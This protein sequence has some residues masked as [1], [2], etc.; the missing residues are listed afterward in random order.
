M[1][2]TR[3]K[4]EERKHIITSMIR[5]ISLC[6]FSKETI[7]TLCATADMLRQYEEEGKTVSDDELFAGFNEMGTM[8]K[9]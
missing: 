7:D 3:E 4:Y 2:T 6:D 5:V 9:E 8:H 1:A